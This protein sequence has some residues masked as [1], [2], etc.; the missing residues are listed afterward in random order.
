MI[1]NEY[2]KIVNE[3]WRNLTT[4]Y[5]HIKLHEYTVMPNHFHG[6]IEITSTT[7][8]TIGNIVGYF[9]YQTT[10]K[11]DL[12]IKLWQRNYYE[13]VIRDAKSYQNRTQYV[14]DNPMNWERDRFYF[15]ILKNRRNAK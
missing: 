3:E 13:S 1:L 4:K 11:I 5:P 10:E 15:S 9:K 6:I 7:D 12:P 2:G 8:V 14:I